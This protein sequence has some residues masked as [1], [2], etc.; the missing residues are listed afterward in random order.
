MSPTRR[1]S[2]RRDSDQMESSSTFA[3]SALA[4]V[5]VCYVL[6]RNTREVEPVAAETRLT[7]EDEEMASIR[8]VLSLSRH[9]NAGA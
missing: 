1:D 7:A 4:A 8:R 2:D 6:Y 5:A 3:A 9:M